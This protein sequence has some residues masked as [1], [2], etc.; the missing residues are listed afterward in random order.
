MS[1]LI[2]I[3]TPGEPIYAQDKLKDYDLIKF[4]SIKANIK[5]PI[6]LKDLFNNSLT[7][8]D[9]TTI[10]NSKINSLRLSWIAMLKQFITAEDD[11][12]F[13]ESDISPSCFFKFEQVNN[14][15]HYDVYRL[16]K[17][18][19][20]KEI[21][22]ET[23]LNKEWLDGKEYLDK[24]SYP[25]DLHALTHSGTHAL[26]IPKRSRHKIIDIFCNK[27]NVTVDAILTEAV[28]QEI[29]TMGILN[30]NAFTQYPH[31]SLIPPTYK[32]EY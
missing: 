20:F 26:I 15:K 25:M 12:I 24:F 30:Y 31:K 21:N 32:W 2:L 4:S 23:P 3:N 14:D 1:K 6:S 19:E 18:V 27:I 29:I 22:Y 11:T 8:E 28:K 13:G 7:K 5:Q 9:N 10:F 17:T 16:F